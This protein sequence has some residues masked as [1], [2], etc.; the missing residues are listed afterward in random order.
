[1][2]YVNV[3]ARVPTGST[4]FA[5]GQELPVG[6]YM[7]SD[8]TYDLLT[9]YTPS[10]AEQAAGARGR[11]QTWTRD[12]P[13]S[14]SAAAVAA[15]VDTERQD[16]LSSREW[17]ESE[18]QG[19]ESWGPDLEGPDGGEPYAAEEFQEPGGVDLV[20]DFGPQ[21]SEPVWEEIESPTPETPAKQE[22]PTTGYDL[23]TYAG[24]VA[25][26]LANMKHL[27]G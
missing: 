14:T 10:A 22:L 6:T 26:N 18:P 21:P 19:V 8:Q 24:R 7:R 17:R 20:E 2:A 4:V 27:W 13:V 11:Q 3:W 23:S 16:K 5:D 9:W 25:Y 12:V 15:L 1:M